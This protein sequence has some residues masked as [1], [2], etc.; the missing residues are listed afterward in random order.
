[1]VDTYTIRSVQSFWKDW[2][3]HLKKVI[4]FFIFFV[5]TMGVGAVMYFYIEHCYDPQPEKLTKYEEHYVEICRIIQNV[6]AASGKG[7]RIPDYNNSETVNNDSLVN[8]KRNSSILMI[9]EA[10]LDVNETCKTHRRQVHI[11]Q[12][13][14]DVNILGSWYLFSAAVGYT[15]GE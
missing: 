15:I 3:R 7:F 8:G 10:F 6:T 2:K 11:P 14:Y 9:V 13:V 12:C 1:M 4:L 5:A